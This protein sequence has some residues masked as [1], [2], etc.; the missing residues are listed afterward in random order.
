M[1]K[2]DIITLKDK[3]LPADAEVYGWID[4]IRHHGGVIF[5]VLRD[6]TGKVQVVIDPASVKVDESLLKNEAVLNISGQLKA[7]P[8]GTINEEEPLGYCELHT[9]NVTW[10]PDWDQTDLPW[11]SPRNSC[12][13]RC[14]KYA[15]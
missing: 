11:D 4:T 12:V 14:P 10:C 3:N 9:Q 7:R 13:C 1:K 5:V 15:H 8:D 2:I 6:R